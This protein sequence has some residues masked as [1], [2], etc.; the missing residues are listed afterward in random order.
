M[1]PNAT[2]KRQHEKAISDRLLDLLNWKFN[3]V[4]EG[5]DKNEPDMIY[6]DNGLVIG[7]E[8]TT[9]YL[10]KEHAKEL[11]AIARKEDYDHRNIVRMDI[12]NNAEKYA[13]NAIYQKAQKKYQ[14]CNFYV[15]CVE[16]NNPLVGDISYINDYLK[17]VIQDRWLDK[18]N[19]D[20]VYLIASTTNQIFRIF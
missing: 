1:N 20:Q 3:F 7:I 4:R 8:V 5:N 15:L 6:H 18:G 10:D 12:D 17:T 16:V 19:F 11:W 9:N 13:L 2:I 14:N